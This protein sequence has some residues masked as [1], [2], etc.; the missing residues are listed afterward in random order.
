MPRPEI[1]KL[2]Y[3]KIVKLIANIQVSNKS[4]SIQISVMIPQVGL[5]S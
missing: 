3:T 2:K 1:M 5:L 4:N